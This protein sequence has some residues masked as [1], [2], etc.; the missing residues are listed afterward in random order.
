MRQHFNVLLLVLCV[1]CVVVLESMAGVLMSIIF[2]VPILYFLIVSALYLSV[3]LEGR[4]ESLDEH[5]NN[6]LIVG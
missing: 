4:N 2:Y 3:A 1:C 5:C 6:I